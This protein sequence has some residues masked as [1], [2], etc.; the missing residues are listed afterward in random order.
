MQSMSFLEYLTTVKELKQLVEAGGRTKTTHTFDKYLKMKFR[1]TNDGL[2]ELKISPTTTV[3]VE[4]VQIGPNQQIASQIIVTNEKTDE[5]WTGESP[6][7]T[8]KLRKWLK[9][10]S[11]NQS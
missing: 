1:D 10:H 6:L 9:Q 7:A 4:W 2:C 5:T 3:V 8:E 11:K